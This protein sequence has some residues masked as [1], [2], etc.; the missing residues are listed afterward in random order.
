MLFMIRRSVDLAELK[1]YLESI[2]GLDVLVSIHDDNR[3]SY[4]GAPASCSCTVR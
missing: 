1:T 4:H 2:L 3:V